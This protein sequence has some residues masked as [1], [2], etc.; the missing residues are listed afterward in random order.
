MVSFSVPGV[1]ERCLG[2]CRGVFIDDGLTFLIP[3]FS[4]FLI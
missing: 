3:Y 1:D 2:L 4:N